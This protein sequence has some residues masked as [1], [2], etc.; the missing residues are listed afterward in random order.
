MTLDDL[1]STVEREQLSIDRD[2]LKL[3]YETAAQA[4]AGQLRLS[5]EPY[6]SHSLAVA[7]KLV[8]LHLDQDTVIAGLLHDVPEDTAVT[9]EQLRHD[10]GD[11]VAKLVA[12]VTKLGKLKYRG[13]QR[14]VENLRKMFVA[15][16]EDI[17]VIL[18]KFADRLHNLE[19]LQYLPDPNKRQ[20][21]AR[22]SLEIYA[23]IANR[24]GIGEIK[25]QLEDLA[26]PY[27]EP[28]AFAATERVFKQRLGD[29]GDLLTETQTALERELKARSVPVLDIHG[30]QKHLYSLYQ[31]LQRPEIDGDITKVY[32][33]VALRLIVPTVADCYAALGVIHGLWRPLPGRIKDYIAQPKPNGYQSIHTTIFGPRNRIIELQVRDQAMHQAAE[34][35]VAAHWH[36]AEAGK[37][38]RASGSLDRTL[39]WVR[40]LSQWQH[41]LEDEQQY[42][43]ALRVDVFSNRIFCLTP[44][45]DVIDL[46]ER[47]TAVDFAYAVHTDLGQ[48]IIGAR[49][50]GQYVDVLTELRSGDVVEV[51]TDKNRKE[52]NPDW[53]PH[54]KTRLA[55]ERIRKAQKTEGQRLERGQANN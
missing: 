43:E 47:A 26:F 53:L 41:E 6:V 38:K 44:K 35:G 31:K 12:G 49:V 13:L 33:L 23:P 27:L 9:I 24:L 4:H 7:D 5:G 11:G 39:G 17:R 50:N 15:M 16:A 25:G 51:V 14:Y 20:R 55:R 52:P 1:L 21:I 37:P 22:E 10:F 2:L 30:R 40:E 34:Y 8:K 18:I 32:D 3:A 42:L 48:R 45:G 36:Y 54:V 19:T 46:P 29:I 28:E